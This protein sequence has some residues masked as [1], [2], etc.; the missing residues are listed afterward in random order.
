MKINASLLTDAL[1]RIEGP[2]WLAAR[3]KAALQQHL[4]SGLPESGQDDWHYT[5][6]DHLARLPLHPPVEDVGAVLPIEPYPGPVVAFLDNQLVWRDAQIPPDLLGDLANAPSTVRD[7]L[8]SLAGESS[9]VMLNSALW[10][11]GVLL[12]VPAREHLRYPIFLRFAAGQ[13]D[14]M[15]HPRV[16]VMLETDADAVLV[17]HYHADTAAPHWQNPVTEIMLEP[18]A[19][20]THLR[21]LESGSATHTHLAAVHQERDSQYHALNLSLGGRVVRLDVDVQL[22]GD[23]AQARLD[24]LFIADGRRHADHHLRVRHQAPRTI[25]QLTWRGIAADRGHGI[26]DARSV[27]EPV[28]RLAEAHQSS[29]N[30][31]LS[32]HAEIDARPQLEIHTDEVRCGHGATVGRLDEAALFYLTSRGIDGSTAREML[33]TAFVGEALALADSAGLRAWLEPRIAARLPGL[34]L[35]AART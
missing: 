23:G 5:R 2:D 10:R 20:L 34:T 14:A 7:R 11:E 15:L 3:R 16:L 13:A 35:E 33:L 4:G 26:L 1:A 6:L 31:L 32:P 19:R 18:G 21:V 28:A 22:A 12:R 8:G 29:R 30:L 24:G 25:S 17:E 9:L 27:I